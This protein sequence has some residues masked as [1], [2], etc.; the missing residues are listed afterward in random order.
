MQ[1]SF[2]WSFISFFKKFNYYPPSTNLSYFKY[3]S[4]SRYSYFVNLLANPS[5][6]LKLLHLLPQLM[7]NLNCFFTSTSSVRSS[8]YYLPSGNLPS[9]VFHFNF[10]EKLF[11]NIT[12]LNYVFSFFC[13]K[14]NKRLFKFSNYKRPRFSIKYVYIPK[15]RRFKH[16]LNILT[17]TFSYLKSSS[18]KG[19]LLDNWTLLMLDP[20][21]T[22]FVKYM[23][24]LQHRVF[25]NKSNRFF[26][27]R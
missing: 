7:F 19:R 22:F 10:I 8:V 12:N 25:H 2:T 6:H 1:S 15:Y 4:L 9:S 17:K 24:L 14:L 13:E 18:F 26:R 21:A 5:K 20:Q 23:Y 3:N 11:S 16:A 27:K